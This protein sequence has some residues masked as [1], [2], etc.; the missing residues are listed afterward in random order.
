MAARKKTAVTIPFDAIGETLAK[1]MDVKRRLIKA[2]I[3]SGNPDYARAILSRLIDQ[4]RDLVIAGERF[5]L[6]A[7][8]VLR[9]IDRAKSRR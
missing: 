9:L 8:D 7:E 1:L 2:S 3:R 5:T 6:S 4:S